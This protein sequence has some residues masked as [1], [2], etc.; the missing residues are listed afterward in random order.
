MILP[1]VLYGNPGLKKKC[2]PID[3]EYPELTDLIENMWQTMYQAHG[4]GL[5]APQVGLNIRLF[6]VDTTQTAKEEKDKAESI[7]QVFINAEMIDE[8]GEPLD[9]EEGCLSI[10]NIHGDVTRPESISIRYLDP[11][12]NLH[13][14]TYTGM[15]ARVIQHEYDHI[16]GILFTEKLKPLKRARLAKKLDKIKKGIV[17]CDYKVKR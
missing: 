10:P 15:N 3:A 1:I 9:Y 11:E 4:V 13:T 2:T 12:F 14:E 17:D 16:E 7:K 6:V 5:A 8:F